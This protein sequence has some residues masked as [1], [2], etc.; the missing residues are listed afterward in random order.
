VLHVYR[1]FHPEYTGDGIYYTCLIRRLRHRQRGAGLRDLYRGRAAD[2]DSG[3]IPVHKLT[4][5]PASGTATGLLRWL[6][7][8]IG[9]FDLIHLHPYLDRR[10]VAYGLARLHGRPVLF[11]SSFDDSPT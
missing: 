3:G 7:A 8:H 4:N 10:F 6:A 5:S 11:S 9:R 1:R 2:G